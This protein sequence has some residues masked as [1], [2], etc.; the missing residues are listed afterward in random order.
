M[1]VVIRFL[2]SIFR[3]IANA[4]PFRVTMLFV[5]N[6]NSSI[7][8]HPMKTRSKTF[9]TSSVPNKLWGIAV[10]FLLGFLLFLPQ[11]ARGDDSASNDDSARDERARN[12]LERKDSRAR[13]EVA[14]LGGYGFLEEG[15]S[16]PFTKISFSFG[17]RVVF[18]F[19]GGIVL[20]GLEDTLFKEFTQAFE[21]AQGKKGIEIPKSSLRYSVGLEI[22]SFIRRSS[23]RNNFYWGVGADWLPQLKT[24]YPGIKIVAGYQLSLLKKK[25]FIIRLGTEYYLYGVVP[26]NPLSLTTSL[27]YRF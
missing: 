4:L 24:Y 19:N 14:V 3:E 9:A 25:N 11:S 27:G 22:R 2:Q 16:A 8:K 20:A 7:G 15:V 17:K 23:E 12:D 1:N 26:G 10:A 18:D 13:G 6:I 5:M 21:S